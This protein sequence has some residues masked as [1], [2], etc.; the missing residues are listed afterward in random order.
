[1]VKTCP[2]CGE[3]MRF[4][5]TYEPGKFATGRYFC[6]KCSSMNRFMRR[7]S[8]DNYTRETDRKTS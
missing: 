8:E 2:D 3:K 4:T 1:M 7:M 6:P 5:Y